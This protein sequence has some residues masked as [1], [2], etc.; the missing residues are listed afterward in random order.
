M[1]LLEKKKFKKII[2]KKIIKKIDEGFV[3]KE[4]N[5]VR[6]IKKSQLIESYKR[7]ISISYF[8]LNKNEKK[9]FEEKTPPLLNK[10][11]SSEKIKLIFYKNL[12]YKKLI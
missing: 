5:I 12:T 10:E 2:E 6:T 11:D 4:K 7:E 1:D 3:I 9:H 8:E